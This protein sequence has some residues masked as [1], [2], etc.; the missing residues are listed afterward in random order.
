MIFLSSDEK[1]SEGMEVLPSMASWVMSSLKVKERP[2]EVE[3]GDEAIAF[4]TEGLGG[5]SGVLIGWRNG[6]V[7]NFVE[8]VGAP[9]TDALFQVEALAQAQ[10]ERFSNPKKP[11]PEDTDDTTVLLDCGDSDLPVYWPG[12]EFAS[13]KLPDTHLVESRGPAQVDSGPKDT[14]RLE[15]ATLTDNTAF[16][17]SVWTSEQWNAYLA[18][19]LGKYA[20]DRP[21]G[22]PRVIQLD[23]R[24]IEIHRPMPGCAQRYV[25]HVLFSN[26]I[27]TIN[28]P[29][30]LCCVGPLE[31]TRAE[32]DIPSALETIA[33]A[34]K[35]R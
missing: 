2:E 31:G 16:T 32:F 24:K 3:V 19:E 8:V 17:L 34:L 29:E 20:T 4:D 9:D 7:L 14:Y 28:V 25:A 26:A 27:V 22:E 30:G 11:E 18:T 15:Y 1:A 6:S 21:C 35:K 13:D 12:K 10:N 23:D 33:R 5:R